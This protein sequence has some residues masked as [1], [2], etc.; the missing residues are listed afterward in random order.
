MPRD[1]RVGHHD[2]MDSIWKAGKDRT[3][4]EIGQ[5]IHDY[6]SGRMGSR[7]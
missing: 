3:Q 6:Q 1:S 7:A 5:V 2:F 4:E